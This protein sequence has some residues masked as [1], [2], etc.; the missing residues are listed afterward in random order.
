M[1]LIKA[2]NTGTD[3]LVEVLH[4]EAYEP[5]SGKRKDDLVV[6]ISLDNG[7]DVVAALHY[8]TVDEALKAAEILADFV[9]NHCK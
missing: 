1:D 9:A 4:A 8:N 5:Y 3:Y 7:D 2:I 6:A